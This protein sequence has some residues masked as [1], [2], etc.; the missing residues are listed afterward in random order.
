MRVLLW[1]WHNGAAQYLI[2]TINIDKHTRKWC[3]RKSSWHHAVISH[4]AIFYLFEVSIAGYPA[5]YGCEAIDV[6]IYSRAPPKCGKLC[7]LIG[8]RDRTYITDLD[9]Q[10]TPHIPPSGA[11][12]VSPI[13]RIWAELDC[14]K[15]VP[16]CIWSTTSIRIKH[17]V[18]S[19]RRT[20]PVLFCGHRRS[21]RY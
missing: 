21:P 2:V 5:V 7:Y 15:M 1:P 10:K 14:D 17:T 16:Y 19:C 3:A 12:H 20:T 11:S 8:C 9:P 13:V 4:K 6:L 18:A